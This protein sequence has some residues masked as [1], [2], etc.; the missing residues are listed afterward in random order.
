MRHPSRP[1]RPKDV[2]PVELRHLHIEEHEVR[3]QR[4]E[5]RESLSTVA[6]FTDDLDVVTLLEQLADPSAC[7]W[8][9]VDDKCADHQAGNGKREAGSGKRETGNGKRETGSGKRETGS[10]KREMGNEKREMG[11][12]KRETRNAKREARKANSDTNANI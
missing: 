7:E 12:E 8:L 2:E 6:T 3:R 10:G 11:N 5:C 1:S 9:V 4:V